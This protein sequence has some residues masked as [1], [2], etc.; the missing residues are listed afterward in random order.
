M[1]LQ[2]YQPKHN[3]KLRLTKTLL[4]ALLVAGTYQAEAA[5][6]NAGISVDSHTYT[7]DKAFDATNASK[8]ALKPYTKDGAGTASISANADLALALYVR[9][10]QV[11]M[12][13]GTDADHVT[14]TLNPTLPGTIQYYTTGAGTSF[15]VA[16]KQAA[17]E[18]NNATLKSKVAT[19]MVVGSPSGNGT[20]VVS[21]GSVIDNQSNSGINFLIGATSN[22]TNHYGA[23]IHATKDYSGEYETL[24]TGGKIGAGYVTVKENSK[25]FG[26]YNGLSIGE[27]SLD[28]EGGSAVYSGFEG[29]VAQNAAPTTSTGQADNFESSIGAVAGASAA[30]NVKDNSTF[31]TGVGLKIGAFDNTD[32]TI[33]VDD[34]SRFE[35]ANRNGGAGKAFIGT[36]F[37][38]TGSDTLGYDRTWT[39]TGAANT[40]VDISVS[41]SSTLKFNDLQIGSSKEKAGEINIELD[42]TSRMESAAMTMYDGTI[43]N[44]GTLSATGAIALNGGKLALNGGTVTA[45]SLSIGAGAELAAIA[46]TNM[47]AVATLSLAEAA[48]LNTQTVATIETALTFEQGAILTLENGSIDMTG[49]ALTLG[50]GLVLNLTCDGFTLGDTVLLFSNVGSCDLDATKVTLAGDVFTTT[51]DFL[52]TGAEL[53]YDSA[54]RTVSIKTIPEPATATLSL[55]ALAALASRRRRH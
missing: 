18:L 4:L 48:T 15:C 28:I 2:L 23:H 36:E 24:S 43:T 8:E 47:E 3:M 34:N 13:N 19:S 54:N 14:V 21:N 35:V 53:V 31:S 49:N 32:V 38:V 39:E 7:E 37:K 1:N 55:L 22:S 41:N 33:N 9:E 16:G 5:R 17:V 26:G 45:N 25:I 51:P 12:G 27:G 46:P 30:V 44:A 29:A 10:G 50:S 52:G 42:S 6:W 11:V 20:L 40:S